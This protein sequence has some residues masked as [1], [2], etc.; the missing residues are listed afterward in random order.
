MVYF[1]CDGCNETLKKNQVDAHASRCRSCYAVTCVDCNHS[2][3]E[4]SYR[5]HTTC[6][7]E[8]EKYEGKLY[9]A[10]NKSKGT[11]KLN[12][13]E[14]WTHVV[15]SATASSAPLLAPHL[16]HLQSFDNVPRKKPKFLKFL[17]NSVRIHQPLVQEGLWQ[18]LEAE[19]LKCRKEQEDSETTPT[20]TTG[21]KRKESPEVETTGSVVKQAKIEEPEKEAEGSKQ[22]LQEI[23]WTWYLHQYLETHDTLTELKKASKAILKIIQADHPQVTKAE[24]KQGFQEHIKVI[25]KVHSYFC[26]N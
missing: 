8:A 6:I 25:S 12:A 18:L 26:S 4:D 14:M 5:S 19:L 9:Q 20:T 15:S 7:S 13:A 1:V 2:F 3:E 16:S 10:P 17:L 23:N 22:I 11:K 24:L 21:N